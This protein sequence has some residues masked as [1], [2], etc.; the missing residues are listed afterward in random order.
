MV[1]Q[2][3]L[4]EGFKMD[5]NKNIKDCATVHIPPPIFFI[6]CLGI[7]LILEYLFP[8]KL[9]GI[10]FLLRMNIGVILLIIA[11]AIAV[12]SFIVLI[13]NKTPFDPAKATIR[14]VK[15]GPFRFSRNPL[16]LSLIIIISG[17]AFLVFSVWLFIAIPVLFLLLHF[18]AVKPEE[19]YLSLKFGEEY[20]AYKNKVRRWI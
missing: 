5:I 17:I 7:A 16:Y 9:Q 11:C 20:Q 18:Y 14:I 15:E 8:V 19:C 2:K 6:L 12:S 1:L 13:R 10:P 3:S 4:S